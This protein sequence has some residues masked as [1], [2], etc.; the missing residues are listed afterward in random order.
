MNSG[1]IMKFH[2]KITEILSLTAG[3]LL[4]LFAIAMGFLILLNIFSEQSSTTQILGGIVF[5]VILILLGIPGIL[6]RLSRD[7]R[8]KDRMLRINGI[9]LSFFM[10]IFP[11]SIPAPPGIPL[12]IFFLG[13]SGL[14]ITL[15]V[16]HSENL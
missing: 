8:K 14:W 2:R 16:F 1:G 4:I 6:S 11:F 3:L 15:F 10:L 12:L 13:A 5:A 9:V 7:I